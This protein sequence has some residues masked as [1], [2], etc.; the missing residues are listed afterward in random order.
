[1]MSNG[2]DGLALSR[3][4]F[5]QLIGQLHRRGRGRLEAGAF[6]LA[7][8]TP[9]SG[10]PLADR[11]AVVA[12]AFYDDL[13]ATSLTGAITLSAN[14][15]AALNSRC[16]T[17]GL[18]V[19]GDIHTHPGRCVGQ[20]AIDAAHP[21]AAVRGHVAI[22]APNFG[23]GPIGLRDLGV[24]VFTAPGWTSHF[25]DEVL[26]VITL[27]TTPAKRH[28]LNPINHA[29]RAIRKLLLLTRAHDKT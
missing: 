4:N 1:M 11:P 8:R 9:S 15:Y 24:H 29:L 28:L 20:S 6:L 23:R 27:S 22:I 13:D 18:R 12:F 10:T 16:R 26:D 5:D 19:V 3:E 17:D 25:G 14:G 7:E 2:R 21:M